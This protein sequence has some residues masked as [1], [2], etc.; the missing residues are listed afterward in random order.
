MGLADYLHEERVHAALGNIPLAGFKRLM[1]AVNS[2]IQLCVRQSLRVDHYRVSVI[3]K[4]GRCR[5]LDVDE[6]RK[7]VTR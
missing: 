2:I 3:L 1:T 7:K 4:V 6:G 5:Q